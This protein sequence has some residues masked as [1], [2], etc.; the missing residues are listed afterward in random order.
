MWKEQS[1]VID[2]VETLLVRE[3]DNVTTEIE[4][5]KLPILVPMQP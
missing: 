1:S 2:G 3:L 5:P 4:M